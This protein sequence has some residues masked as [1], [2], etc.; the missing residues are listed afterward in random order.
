MR[1]YLLESGDLVIR[2]GDFVFVGEGA[3]TRQRLEQKLRLWRGEYWLDT[4]KGF[5]WLQEIL[6]ERPTPEV[7]TSIIRGLLEDDE[8]V[9]SIES[10]SV[11]FEGAGRNLDISFRAILTEGGSQN[12]EVQL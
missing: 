7:V 4:S 2:N 8:G 11:D 9:R 12:I 6:G 10:L 3:A 5:P 1:D